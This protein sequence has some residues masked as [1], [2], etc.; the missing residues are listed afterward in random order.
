[1][2]I[3]IGEL[4]LEILRKLR[5]VLYPSVF[6]VFFLV[7]SYCSFPSTV[8]RS[9]AETSLTRAALGVAPSSRGFPK[10]S[11]KDISLWR[12]SGADLKDVAISWPATKKEPPISFDIDN[13]KGRLGIMGLLSGS[14]NITTDVKL[15]G[16]LVST[17]IKTNKQKILTNLNIKASKLNL[18]KIDFIQ[19]FIGAPLQGI[20]NLTVDLKASSQLSKDGVGN[21][22]L[23][24]EQGVFGP[25]NLKLPPATMVP[26][27]SVPQI[28][29]GVLK[30]N[31]TLDKGQLESK[32]F[33]L[34]GGDLEADLQLTITL[35]RI[36]ALSR[37]SGRG[38]FSLKKELVNSNETFKMLFDLIPELRAAKNGDGK[39]GFIL[40]GTLG[41][42]MP[43]LDSSAV[44]MPPP[45]EPTEVSPN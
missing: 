2:E 40:G 12:L 17:D 34:S 18:G 38:W 23:N 5:W 28:S 26:S 27:I 31:F 15:Y 22:S 45:K 20:L 9:F 30:A 21:L 10:V 13:L 3:H 44:R 39:V 4:A 42:P 41:R 29:L 14:Q 37:L 24:L 19:A 6:I 25:G 33:S 8:L 16:G 35:G 11:I 43:R 36:P 7:G 1:M 32:S